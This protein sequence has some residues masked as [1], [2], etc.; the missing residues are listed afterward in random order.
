[1]AHT[2]NFP[3]LEVSLP[4]I[5]R[6]WKKLAARAAPADCA[7]VVKA[8]AYGLGMAEV[9]PALWDAGCR[10]FF[11]A[12]LAEGMELRRVFTE[13]LSLP[14]PLKEE[15]GYEPALY[16]FHGARAGER[17]EFAA[18]GLIPVINEVSE[19]EHWKDSGAFALH[20]DTGMCRLGVTP[21]AAAVI[22]QKAL[23]MKHKPGLILSHLACANEP[24]NPKNAEQLAAFRQ[25]LALFPGM[26]ASFANSS[27]VFL[28]KDYHFDLARPG[29]SLYGIS[30]NTAIANPMENVVTLSAPVLQYRTLARRESVGYGA[31]ATAEAGRVLAT[32]ELGYADGYLRSLS[33]KAVGF[34]GGVEVPLMGR[35]SMDMVSVDVTDVPASLRT[36]DL[37][38]TFIGDALPVDAVA[39]AAGTIG[40]E[41]FTR[42]GRRVRR[43]YI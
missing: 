36:G 24:G 14:F 2:L 35:V 7:A 21:E 28:G 1:M 16:V 34:A 43:I 22:A 5:Q 3:T 30:P 29:C 6:N 9:A 8:N 17:K 27:G 33:N 23:G 18:H 4:A 31:T 41:I 20:V 25:A 42:L 39:E 15:E 11:V 13:A 38:V 19:L 37:R 12:T 40:Y 26:R 10:N 32:V